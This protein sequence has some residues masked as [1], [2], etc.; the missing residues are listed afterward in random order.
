[1]RNTPHLTPGHDPVLASQIRRTRAG[2]AHWAGSGPAGA[3]CG[4]C[5]F[6]GYWKKILSASGDTLQS[7]RVSGCQKF[8]ELTGKHGAVVPPSSE[9]CRHFQRREP[10]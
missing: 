4:E 8:R 9:A 5:V 3:T 1:M 10:V 2:M 7:Q 6:L